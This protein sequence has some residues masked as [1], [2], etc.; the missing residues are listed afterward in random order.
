[1][2]PEERKEKARWQRIH[3]TYGITQKEYE[4]LDKGHC[5]ICLKEWGGTIV[6]CIDHDHVSNRVRGLLCRWCNRYQVGNFRDP[7]VVDRIAKYLRDAFKLPEYIIPPK[8]KRRRRKKK[9]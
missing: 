8:K 4:S 3:R 7:E 9:K 6:P 2:T 5:P 1:M